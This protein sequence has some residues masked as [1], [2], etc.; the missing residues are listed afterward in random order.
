MGVLKQGILGGVKGKVGSVVGSSWKGIA[1]LRALPLSVANPR[2]AA[3]VGNRE[4]FSSIVALATVLLSAIIKPLND[5]FAS[6]MSG[7]N[8]FVQR[9]KAAFLAD[10]TFVPAALIVSRGKLGATP[11]SSV[12]ADEGDEQVS[13]GFSEDLDNGYQSA[14]DKAYA[15]VL[16]S[17]GNLL[18]ISSALT[19]RSNAFLIVPLNR[20]VV[21]GE[22]IHCYLSFLRADGTMCADSTYLTK[23]VDTI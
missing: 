19:L 15:F 3:Q 16:D 12:I 17:N 23:V 13:I 21:E 10:G 8:L 1:T 9:C 5:R 4:R 18:G 6:G 20:V 14:S 2:T 11:I 7:Y 22:T